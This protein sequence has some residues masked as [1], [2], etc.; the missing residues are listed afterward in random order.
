MTFLSQKQL[1]KKVR[2]VIEVALEQQGV[3]SA[4][5]PLE[6]DDANIGEGVS[7]GEQGSLSGLGTADLKLAIQLK[8]L[9]LEIKRQAHNTGATL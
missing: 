9:D 3:L 1:E 7:G 5:Q 4:V 6:S 8:Q 2:E